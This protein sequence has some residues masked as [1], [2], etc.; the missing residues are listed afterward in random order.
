MST[1]ILDFLHVSQRLNRILKRLKTFKNSAIKRWMIIDPATA[2]FAMVR[3]CGRPTL[4]LAALHRTLDSILNHFVEIGL[5]NCLDSIGCNSLPWIYGSFRPRDE[6]R[7]ALFAAFPLGAFSGF[8]YGFARAV[9]HR[10]RLPD[11]RRLAY[12]SAEFDIRFGNAALENARE[13][14]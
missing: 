14:I 7:S 2:K 9:H 11:K 12:A 4:R 1:N 5:A 13:V 6:L 8:V 3:F 10:D